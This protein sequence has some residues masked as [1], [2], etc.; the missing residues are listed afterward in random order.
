MNK[1]QIK[2]KFTV[3]NKSR[4]CFWEYYFEFEGE[5]VKVCQNFILKLYQISQQ[6]LRTIQNKLVRSL[7]ILDKRGA[8]QSH[9][10]NENAILDHFILID[11][12]SILSYYII[13]LCLHFNFQNYY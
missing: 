8:H 6:R 12:S 5:K 4:S 9:N 13:I 10:K 11:C 7:P 3:E 1:E 2:S